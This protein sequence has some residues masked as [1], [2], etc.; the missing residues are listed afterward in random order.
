MRNSLANFCEDFEFGAVR[1]SVHLVAKNAKNEYLV[2]KIGVD[3]AENEDYFGLHATP[4]RERAFE[5]LIIFA[6]KYR[7]Y[8][9]ESFNSGADDAPRRRGGG[10]PGR[11]ASL[12]P[13]D[14]GLFDEARGQEIRGVRR[15]RLR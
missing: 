13:A 2:A 3:T 11:G 15:R 1:R 8:C 14:G 6:E 12:V 5:S 7:I 10:A 9:I 4:R